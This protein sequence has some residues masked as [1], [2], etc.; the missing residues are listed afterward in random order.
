VILNSVVQY[1]P[2]I[3]Y[4]MNV[5]EGAVKVVRPGG[6]IFIGDVRNFSYSKHSTRAFKCITHLIALARRLAAT[7]TEASATRKRTGDRSCFFPEL[8]KRF[9]EIT[10]VQVQLKRGQYVNELTAFRY[11]V[12]L[13]IRGAQLQPH[14]REEI[15]WQQES[16]GL[17]R[18]N[19]LVIA[20]ALT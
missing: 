10:G 3:D 19:Q 8:P 1:F 6:S 17:E 11:D 13:E 14:K 20:L 9:P 5:L 12:V 15:D 7:N 4:L 2:T 18:L 16:D